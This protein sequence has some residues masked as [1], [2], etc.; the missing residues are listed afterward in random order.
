MKINIKKEHKDAC[1]PTYAYS[2][3]AC[4]DIR[5]VEG[6]VIPAGE[7]V[8]F[9]TGLKFEVPEGYMLEL[10]PR[11]GLS[12]KNKLIIPNSPGTLDSHYRGVLFIV[13]LN[14]GK[15]SVEIKKGDRITQ[16]RIVECIHTEFEFVDEVS[17]TDRGTGGFNSTGR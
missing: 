11:S 17:E 1:V 4:F 6:A 7:S 9:S 5:T 10:R 14:L 12:C 2:T 8:K 16:G 15:E 3:D 13:L